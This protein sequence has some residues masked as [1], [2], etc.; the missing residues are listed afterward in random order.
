MQRWMPVILA[1]GSLLPTTQAVSQDRDLVPVGVVVQMTG[2]WTV[3]QNRN[4]DLH[5]ADEVLP[6]E[7]I[8]TPK[9]ST[10][11]ITIWLYDRTSWS[12]NCAQQIP[13]PCNGQSLS[14]PSPPPLDS[15]LIPFLK[16]YFSIQ[17]DPHTIITAGRGIESVSAAESANNAVLVLTDEI[18]LTPALQG[19]PPGRL[20][21]AL[22]NPDNPDEPEIA[23]T[24][25]WPRERSANFGAIAPGIYALDLKKGKDELLGSA[26]TVLLLPP[27][28][29]AAA[30]ERFAEI[31]NFASQFPRD[32]SKAQRG[33][34]SRALF[35]LALEFRQ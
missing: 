30:E 18:D 35:A 10:N 9:S 32:D 15:G 7:T 4:R 24:V 33:F 6:S 23:R 19:H 29:A 3:S 1:L 11:S 20:Q 17:A 26:A 16:K 5:V 28:S 2:S 8:R 34:L 25:D 14:L 22:S 27:L 21:I 13:Q 12:W 31:R